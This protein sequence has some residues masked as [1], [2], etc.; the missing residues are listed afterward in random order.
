MQIDASWAAIRRSV[1]VSTDEVFACNML[2]QSIMFTLVFNV[3]DNGLDAGQ[4]SN[5]SIVETAAFTTALNFDR[6]S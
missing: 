2:P 1:A 4:I 6:G 3:I 5:S